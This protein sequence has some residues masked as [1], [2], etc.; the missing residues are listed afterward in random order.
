MQMGILAQM[1]IPE[2][3]QYNSNLCLWSLSNV[4]F[5]LIL[6]LTMMILSWIQISGHQSI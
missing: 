6:N 2:I 1:A 3:R 5:I 4:F